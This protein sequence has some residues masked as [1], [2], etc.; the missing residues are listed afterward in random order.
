LAESIISIARSN[1]LS[2]Q[3]VFGAPLIQHWDQLS[4]LAHLCAN[5]DNILSS[6]G[7]RKAAI[8][9]AESQTS[10]HLENEDRGEDLYN[11][12]SGSTA[13][14]I[15]ALNEWQRLTL[16]RCVEASVTRQ[17]VSQSGGVG[18]N[19]SSAAVTGLVG[20]AS[21]PSDNTAL[22]N[23]MLDLATDPLM[24]KELDLCVE[25]ISETHFL[26]RYRNLTKLVV[27]VNKIS[28][29]TGISGLSS[30]VT[31]SAKDNKLS[32][33]DAIA[34][35]KSL[36]YLYVDS[37]KLNDL[38]SLNGLGEL[39]VLTANS[40]LITKM[41]VLSLAN[42]QR[43]ELF[44]NKISSVGV[45]DS[46]CLSGVPLLTHLDLGSN[47]ITA[48]N[49]DALSACGLLQTLILSQNLLT[50]VPSPLHLPLLKNLWLNGNQITSLGP[51][52]SGVLPRHSPDLDHAPQSQASEHASWPLFLPSLQKLIIRDNQI[53][54][55]ARGMMEMTPLLIE[56]D[57]SFNALVA[58]QEVA[59]I[60]YCSYLTSFHCQDNH[61]T[62][63]PVNTATGTSTTRVP[64]PET[65]QLVL[66][67]WLMGL[68]PT[69][70]IICGNRVDRND[71]AKVPTQEQRANEYI[72]DIEN[73]FSHPGMRSNDCSLF[74][75]LIHTLQH[76]NIAQ[77]AASSREKIVKRVKSTASKSSKAAVVS[78]HGHSTAN[79]TPIDIDLEANFVNLLAEHK[80]ILSSLFRDVSAQ[81]VDRLPLVSFTTADEVSHLDRSAN[82]AI[83][84]NMT[85]GIAFE[86]QEDN[87]GADL[88]T[89]DWVSRLVCPSVTST[90]TNIQHALVDDQAGNVDTGGHTV[91][92][93]CRRVFQ[94]PLK[95]VVLLQS[96]CRGMRARRRIGEALKSIRYA[97]NELD[98]LFGSGMEGEEFDFE[99][100]MSELSQFL[101]ADGESTSTAAPLVYGDHIRKR[102]RQQP[103]G[104][105]SF[106]YVDPVDVVVTGTA[107]SVTP[108]AAAAAG[109]GWVLP[110]GAPSPTTGG[111][112][113]LPSTV[114]VGNPAANEKMNEYASR[115]ST[116]MSSLSAASAQTDHSYRPSI[117]TTYQ[118][119]NQDHHH[120]Q[121][122][123]TSP[124]E[125]STPS[126]SSKRVDSLAQ[127]WG[128]SDPKVLAAMMKR[129][130]RM[131]GFASAKETRAQAKDPLARLERFRKTA[132]RSGNSGHSTVGNTATSGSFGGKPKTVRTGAGNGKQQRRHMSVPAWMVGSEEGEGENA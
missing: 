48:A 89:S 1:N 79:S 98:D 116:G 110:Q 44:R 127:E 32:T 2:P 13:P 106:E 49:G 80:R 102:S 86:A 36:R 107:E 112:K 77:L 101:A 29:F 85:M 132:H 53:T 70:E 28:R 125:F 18:R 37:N 10:S 81:S 130:Q 131:K 50:E 47:S 27:N 62:T 73:Q 97:D 120:Q 83:T 129:N 111:A 109:S 92:T 88:L 82:D 9:T 103:Q 95:V 94:L 54:Q 96:R 56:L 75:R 19:D 63:V 38:S 71:L 5:T 122:N 31:L 3:D 30:L 99:K 91:T 20:Q 11:L 115:P 59:S 104:N 51:W 108:A 23:S 57:V 118:H 76:M 26:A 14:I 43:L 100:E 33:L 105:S 7:V 64:F 113:Q 123:L 126:N 4:R 45:A 35:L 74:H 84:K 67:Q 68:C 121:H 61:F 78:H 93:T 124:S 66:N 90:P 42:L 12:G 69:L 17:P 41:P 87:D 60:R 72:I 39:R 128:I 22:N 58:R 119:E 34:S 24:A 46:H 117:D 52:T 16:Q 65:E 40:N 55:I 6:E 21:P 114:V 25:G 15:R 8:V